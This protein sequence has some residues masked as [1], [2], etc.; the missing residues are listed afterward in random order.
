MPDLTVETLG[1]CPQH[2]AVFIVPGSAPGTRYRVSLGI[3]GAHCECRAFQYCKVED[4]S[5]RTCK[6]VAL[7]RAHGCLYDP[8]GHDPGPNDLPDHG[9]EIVSQEGGY[10]EPCPGCGEDMLPVRV[11][12]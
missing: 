9:V 12:V 8:Q 1:F 3:E 5:D 7:V 11:A 6:H 4:E 2:D 10:G